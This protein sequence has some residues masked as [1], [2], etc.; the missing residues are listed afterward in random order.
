LEQSIDNEYFRSRELGLAVPGAQVFDPEK[1]KQVIDGIRIW[2]ETT[3]GDGYLDLV[4][5]RF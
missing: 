4:E 2:I 1:C 3:E 5:H